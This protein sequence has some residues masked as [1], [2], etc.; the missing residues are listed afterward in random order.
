MA[1][2]TS[3]TAWGLAA[4]LAAALLGALSPLGVW[5]RFCWVARYH[6]QMADLH[7]ALLMFAPLRRAQ[8]AGANL[9][10][11]NLCG[12]DLRD[13]DITMANLKDARLYG[14]NL[15]GTSGMHL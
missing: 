5:L 13:A 2:K 6:G 10:G 9:R 4:I 1:K 12:A 15:R 7:G 8:L 3:L 14:A 11:A